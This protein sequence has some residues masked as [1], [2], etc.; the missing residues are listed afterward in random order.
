[1]LSLGDMVASVFEPYSIADFKR[2]VSEIQRSADAK[3]PGE[4]SKPEEARLRDAFKPL[5]RSNSAITVD[6]KEAPKDRVTFNPDGNRDWWPCLLIVAWLWP[7]Y[8]YYFASKPQNE[9]RI[10]QRIVDLP[11]F[12]FGLTWLAAVAHY[13]AKVG[14]YRDLYGEPNAHVILTFAAGAFLVGAFA[15]Y[16]NLE[17]TQ[18]YVRKPIARPFFRDHN[19][20]GVKSGVRVGAFLECRFLARHPA[21]YG[22]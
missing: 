21:D 8:R 20:H 18:L 13:F 14:L 5:G 6:G 15:G 4:Q 9:R 19:P 16:L 2:G 12:L 3:A 10:E 22:Q 1:M 11:L 7:L 17:L